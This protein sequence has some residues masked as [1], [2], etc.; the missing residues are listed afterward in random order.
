MRPFKG[1]LLNWTLSDTM[2][3]IKQP[4]REENSKVVQYGEEKNTKGG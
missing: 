3:M 1:N 2:K 4:P